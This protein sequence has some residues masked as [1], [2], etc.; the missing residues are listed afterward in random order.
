MTRD[1]WLPPPATI[2]P[3]RSLGH[4]LALAALHGANCN[5]ELTGRMF[6]IPYIV[7]FVHEATNGRCDLTLFRIS[8]TALHS[9]AV[10]YGPRD[11]SLMLSLARVGVGTMQS[12]PSARLLI[13]GSRGERHGGALWTLLLERTPTHQRY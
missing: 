1:T 2:S 6:R 9:I 4:H 10:H 5:V 8:E 7:Y 13:C 3:D 12:N 11:T